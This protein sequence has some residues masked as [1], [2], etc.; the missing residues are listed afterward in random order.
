M[1]ISSHSTACANAVVTTPKQCKCGCDGAFHGGPHTHRARALLV[2][3]G[4]RVSYSRRQVR[5]A[6][7]K[8]RETL[9]RSPLSSAP[10]ACTDLI[11]FSTIDQLITW[12]TKGDY[13]NQALGI[14]ALVVKPFAATLAHSSLGKTDEKHLKKYMV[15][16]HVLCSLCV[17]ILKVIDEVEGELDECV[18]AVVQRVWTTLPTADTPAE[19]SGSP[20]QETIME[21]LSEGAR[22]LIEKVL[23]GSDLKMMVQLLGLITCPNVDCHPEVTDYCLEPLSASWL[24]PRLL[25][26]ANNGYPSIDPVLADLRKR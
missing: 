17:E 1:P 25:M 6:K 4:E 12:D 11:G 15:E 10:K 24:G 5:E 23:T 2:P 20:L 16:W 22:P 3:Q 18:R 14:I 7:K 13:Q 8:V 9:F 19:G 26:W 21:A